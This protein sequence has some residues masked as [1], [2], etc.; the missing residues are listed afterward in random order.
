LLALGLEFVSLA[1]L[2]PVAHA[3]NQT[4]MIEVGGG[5]ETT[6]ASPVVNALIRVGLHF[7][8]HPLGGRQQL[9]A[10]LHSELALQRDTEGKSVA[11]P[12]FD[13]TFKAAEEFYGVIDEDGLLEGG[14]TDVLGALEV[15]RD[16]GLGEDLVMTVSVVGTRA[17]LASLGEQKLKLF[18]Q[19]AA[20][21]FGYRV[22]SRA[23]LPPSDSA[24][25]QLTHDFYLG[26]VRMDIGAILV[27]TPALKL[28][29]TVGGNADL[30][31]GMRRADPAMDSDFGAMAEL[32]V[33]IADLIE[34]FASAGVNGVWNGVWNSESDAQSAVRTDLQIKG[35]IELRF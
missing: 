23:G 22:A 11:V 10:Q 35:G 31:I 33:D 2:V 1:T 4:A 6:S 25:G 19:L 14:P 5:A 8:N 32:R 16:I 3:A 34:L 29:L 27:A 9:Y 15:K 30:G 26:K 24:A 7:H 13:L 28:R 12:Y 21:G 20:D 18:L 17:G